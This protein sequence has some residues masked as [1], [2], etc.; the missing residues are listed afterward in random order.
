LIITRTLLIA[1]AAAATA[2]AT[3]AFSA[4][5]GF[6]D[7][8]RH[9]FTELHG[10]ATGCADESGEVECEFDGQVGEG[11]KSQHN[12]GAGFINTSEASDQEHD[13]VP[14]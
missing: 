13:R 9:L 10:F 3:T 2:A 11:V 8:L 1:A 4:T 5:A 14:E 6:L 12:N 7:S